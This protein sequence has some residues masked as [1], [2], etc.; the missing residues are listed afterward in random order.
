M[1][2]SL[3]ITLREGLEA[4]LIIGI[5]LGYLSKINQKH[6]YGHIFAGTGLGIAGSIVAAILFVNLAGGF[7]G[8]A[9]EIFEGVVMLV[10]VVILSSMVLWMNRQSRSI[11][12]EIQQKVDAAVGKKHVW[13]LVS[14]A[15][16][17]VF[18]EGI[19]VVL[20]INATVVNVST[21]NSLIGGILG[22]AAAIVIAWLVFKSAVNLN[23]KSFFQITGAFII[24]IAAGMI[25]GGIHELEEAGI[26]PV[27][28]EHLWD[29]NGIFNE[30]STIGSFFKAVFG[31]NGNPSISEV[32]AYV[33]YLALTIRLF[34]FKKRETIMGISSRSQKS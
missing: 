6:F 30:K 22:L 27:F 32:V 34:F 10:A 29:I 12:T 26:L 4:A 23:L 5:I 7:E 19:E 2:G 21:E 9:E 17:S 31:Y 25:A 15:F 3:L 16:V 11:G 24:L 20:F 33:S 28:I 14:L 13:D 1:F 18:R 8:K